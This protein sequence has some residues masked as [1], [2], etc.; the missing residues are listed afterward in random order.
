MVINH[1]TDLL[2]DFCRQIFTSSDY[3]DTGKGTART[4]AIVDGF[5]DFK[6]S[7][8]SEDFPYIIIRPLK[9][10]IVG[11][12]SGEVSQRRDRKVLRITVLFII[13]TYAEDVQGYRDGL[14]LLQRL[15]IAF[16]SLPGHILG[17]KFQVL[18]SKDWEVQESSSYPQWITTLQA[19]FET[20][21]PQGN[22]L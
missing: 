20:G 6:Q 11:A 12:N 13:G 9:G 18:E 14:N 5:L 22:I 8:D 16:E 1:L 17:R 10:S 21:I 15:L 7:R 2:I 3:L 19:T 4:P